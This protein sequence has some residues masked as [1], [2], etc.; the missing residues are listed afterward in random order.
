VGVHQTL[1]ATVIGKH[2]IFA[3]YGIT[4]PVAAVLRSLEAVIDV[5][6]FYFHRN[7]V[8]TKFHAVKVFCFRY[9]QH[10]PLRQRPCEQRP[11]AA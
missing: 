2:S 8:V 7:T 1:L 5:S 3:Q 4:A 11:A 10:D 9:D 6:S